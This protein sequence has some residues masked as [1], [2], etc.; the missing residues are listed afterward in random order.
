MEETNE[1]NDSGEQTETDL[2][3]RWPPTDGNVIPDDATYIIVDEPDQEPIVMYVRVDDGRPSLGDFE[4]LKRVDI[5]PTTKY[6]GELMMAHCDKLEEIYIPDTVCGVGSGVFF[7]CTSLRKVRLPNNEHFQTIELGAFFGCHTL[8]SV[9]IPP[10][11][12]C[13]EERA[14]SGCHALKHV[15]LPDSVEN[16]GRWAFDPCSSMQTIRLPNNPDLYIVGDSFQGCYSLCSI[17]RPPTWSQEGWLGFIH[18]DVNQTYFVCEDC[19][20]EWPAPVVLHVATEGFNDLGQREFQADIPVKLWPKVFSMTSSPK[21]YLPEAFKST[22]DSLIFQH[23]RKHTGLLL[24]NRMRRA[25]RRPRRLGF[26]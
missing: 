15:T 2:A 22:V 13:I 12:S 24:D 14:F 5:A 16:I 6:L 7:E 25:R 8:T 18:E 23:L 26:E 17:I 10:T 9:E 11:V 19:D 21:E 3:Y 1:A 4:H 20:E